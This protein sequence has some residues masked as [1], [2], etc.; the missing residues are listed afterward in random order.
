LNDNFEVKLPVLLQFGSH[1]TMAQDIDVVKSLKF[2][3][4][5]V[6]SVPKC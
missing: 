6:E 1:L 3:N 5:H 4:R 2:I